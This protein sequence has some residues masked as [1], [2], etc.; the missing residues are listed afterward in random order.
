MTLMSKQPEPVE[1]W[2][3][4]QEDPLKYPERDDD[5]ATWAA[6]CAAAETITVSVAGGAIC[7]SEAVDC[8]LAVVWELLELN[9]L[10]QPAFEPVDPE[11]DPAAPLA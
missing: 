10:K 11:D 9:G 6:R 1:G 7:F 3:F 4:V 5:R 2:V 8:P